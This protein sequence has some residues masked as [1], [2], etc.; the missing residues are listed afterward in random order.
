MV[1]TDKEYDI[2]T[3]LLG[4]N[5]ET[6]LKTMIHFFTKY[7]KKEDIIACKDF[8]CVKGGIPVTLV[9]HV[10]T[11]FPQ[12]PSQESFFYDR[13]KNV[14]WSC[15]GAGFDDR[16]G[17]YL[18][19]KIIREGFLPNIILTTG[20]E[21]G[22]TGADKLIS[23]YPKPFAPMNYIIELDRNGKEDC[24]FYYCDNKEFKSYV[25]SFGFKE[26]FGTFTDISIICP[27]WGIAG[28]NFSVGYVNEHS[29]CEH[30][31]ID[32]MELTFKR[33]CAMLRVARD[34]NEP[35]KYVYYLNDTSGIKC[36]C[37]GR[38]YLD[39]DV[40]PVM[41]ANSAKKEMFCVDCISEKVEWCKKC[42]EPF[43]I[44]NDQLT[45]ILCPKCIEEAAKDD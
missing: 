10:D 22:G 8:V 30:L 28:V 19:T 17:I 37:C 35:F 31:Y 42:G 27:H 9:A 23:K 34:V 29:Y 41:R 44:P 1:L 3:K 11:V 16:A 40:Y 24:V 45:H 38:N 2:F 5:D 39:E 43:E 20:E 33:V 32:H 13:K 36:A 15:E 6:L 4:M 12:W 18:I 7:Y 14:M 25:S 26:D 21:S